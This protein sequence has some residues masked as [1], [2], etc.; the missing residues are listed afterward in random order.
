MKLSNVSF[1]FAIVLEFDE[2]LSSKSFKQ[3]KI[4]DY[5][6]KFKLK[7]DDIK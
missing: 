7:S 4:S 1:S 3:I 2:K 5:K 6:I